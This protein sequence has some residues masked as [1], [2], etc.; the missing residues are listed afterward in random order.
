MQVPIPTV[1][2][3]DTRVSPAALTTVLLTLAGTAR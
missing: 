1:T 3:T 2:T